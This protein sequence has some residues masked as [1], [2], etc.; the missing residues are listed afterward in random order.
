MISTTTALY[1]A[2]GRPDVREPERLG[3]DVED[4]YGFVCSLGPT[5]RLIAGLDED[6]RAAALGTLHARLTEHA[7]PDGV[8]LDAAAWLV[9]ARRGGPG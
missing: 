1:I 7:G 5:R 6:A 9:T 2:Q 4:A 8:L 3:A